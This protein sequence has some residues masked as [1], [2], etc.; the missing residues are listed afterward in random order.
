MRNSKTIISN[1]IW[2]YFQRKKDFGQSRVFL[3]SARD[4]ATEWF[5]DSV[6]LFQQKLLAVPTEW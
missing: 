5:Q 3:G 1:T 2:G 6:D 4:D